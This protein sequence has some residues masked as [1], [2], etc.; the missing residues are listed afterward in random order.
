[1]TCSSDAQTGAYNGTTLLDMFLAKVNNCREYY[2]WSEKD[3]VHHL[4]ANL[5]GSAAQVLIDFDSADVSLESITSLLRTR[6]GDQNQT[7]RFR[8]KLSTRRR[9][10]GDSLQA[11]YQDIG[12]L[13][14]LAFPGQTGAKAGSLY[15]IVLGMPSWLP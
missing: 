5:E 6:F 4:S 2:E 8:S 9:A 11:V 7:E 13:V 1:M 12:R 3:T 15:E 14:A 10:K